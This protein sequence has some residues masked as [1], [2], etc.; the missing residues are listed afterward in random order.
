MPIQIPSAIAHIS[1]DTLEEYAFHR[2]PE[3]DVA[4]VE[5]H[6][7]WC[8]VCLHTLES[9]DEFILAMKHGA[10]PAAQSTA[11]RHVPASS[12]SLGVALAA[13]ALGLTMTAILPAMHRAPVGKPVQLVAF[14][15]GEG[16]AMLPADAG[17]ALTLS[18][19]LA[20]LTPSGVYRIQ[21][22]D[23][24]GNQVW[25]GESRASD[26]A[27]KM[28]MSPGLTRGSY[29]IRLYSNGELLREFGLRAQ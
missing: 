4:A 19:D 5:E 9:V 15:G 8:P 23:A 24:K 20:D 7:L 2:L 11:G 17:A 26:G 12:I 16:G 22:V 28:R 14:R 3:N 29:W 10:R 6:L 13:A 21:I 1:E 18:V 27:L 25:N